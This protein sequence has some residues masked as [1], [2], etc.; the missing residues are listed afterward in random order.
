MVHGL[1]RAAEPAAPLK[2]QL[3]R[4]TPPRAPFRRAR[5]QTCAVRW[6]TSEDWADPVEDPGEPVEVSVEINRMVLLQ[7]SGFDVS[8]VDGSLMVT[9]VAENCPTW[10]KLLAGDILLSINGVALPQ[11]GCQL[12]DVAQ[13]LMG[14]D[15][16]TVFLVLERDADQKPTVLDF[17]EETVSVY[18]IQMK[19]DLAFV[20]G[21]IV[22]HGPAFDEAY[23]GNPQNANGN[24]Q[25]ATTLLES[26]GLSKEE[27]AGLTMEEF[28]DLKAALTASWGLDS[29]AQ[30]PEPGGATP[31]ANPPATLDDI[32]SNSG[33]L[34]PLPGSIYDSSGCV[35][36]TQTA[37]PTASTADSIQWLGQII[38]I[39]V[40]GWLIVRWMDKSFTKV[41]Q[42]PQIHAALPTAAAAAAATV[43]LHSFPVPSNETP[44]LME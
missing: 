25:N 30:D 1:L 4:L 10:N 41:Q 27:V 8:I 32:N 5:R 16:T 22:M 36:N 42:P 38:E 7:S 12:S 33:H 17:A 18:D 21:D 44:G 19:D 24:P 26:A 3:S 13:I 43:S 31:G 6:L 34:L 39:T 15:T 23:Y 11:D 14:Q 9:N 37:A 35:A 20:L 29:A 28:R 40:D 2:Y